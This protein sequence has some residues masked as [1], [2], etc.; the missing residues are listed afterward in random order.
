MAKSFGVKK[1][2]VHLS[3]SFL[4]E[5]LRKSYNEELALFKKHHKNRMNKWIHF[6]TVP[7][8]WFSSFLIISLL[9]PFTWFWTIVILV[10]A[11]LCMLGSKKKF[12]VGAIHMLIAC[13][14]IWYKSNN[15]LF[16]SIIVAIVGQL[17]AWITQIGIGHMLIEKNSP[18]MT[19]RFTLNSIVVSLLLIADN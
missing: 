7:I 4:F 9:V 12:L 19:K 1:K 17:F 15:T 2:T 18:S 16:R 10:Y 14:S 13:L 6:I 11:Y 5:G 3:T 8:E